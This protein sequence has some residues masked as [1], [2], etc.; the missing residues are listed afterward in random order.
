M[1]MDE[2]VATR[3]R[4]ELIGE[5]EM[6]TIGL[7]GDAGGTERRRSGEKAADEEEVDQILT[8]D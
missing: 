8:Y 2:D 4:D 1:E 7:E 6:D 5:K 3:R